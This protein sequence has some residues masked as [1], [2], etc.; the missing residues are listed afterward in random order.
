VAALESDASN[1]VCVLAVEPMYSLPGGHFEFLGDG[2]SQPVIEGAAEEADAEQQRRSVWKDSVPLGDLLLGYANSRGDAAVAAHERASLRDNGTFLVVRKLEQNVALLRAVVAENARLHGVSPEDLYAKLVGRDRAGKAV[3]GGTQGN[4][5]DYANDAGE[6]CPLQ[7]HIRLANPRIERVPRILRRSMSY[8]PPLADGEGRPDLV[9]APRGMFFMAYNASIT[10]Q[11]EVI[12]RWL[13]GANSTGIFSGYGDPLLGVPDREC[14]RIFRFIHDDRAIAC[15]LD[16]LQ[17]H[18]PRPFVQLRWGL[19][20]FMP[21]REGL[22]KILARVSVA[23]ASASI[24]RGQRILEQLEALAISDPDEARDSWRTLLEDPSTHESGARTALWTA[25]R[26]L[27]HGVVKTPYGVVVASA[28]TIETVFRNDSDLYS[29]REYAERMERSAGKIFLGMDRG[30]GYG[31]ESGAALDA[32]QRLDPDRA[33]ANAR[34]H[35]ALA[36]ARLGTLGGAFSVMDVVDYVLAGVSK[37][38]FDLPDGPLEWPGDAAPAASVWV[39]AGPARDPRE[40]YCPASFLMP[41]R[42]MFFPQPTEYVAQAGALSGQLLAGA[43]R[44]F[45]MSGATLQGEISRALQQQIPGDPERLAR[46][47]LGVM[48]GFLPTV[49]GNLLATAHQWITDEELWRLQQDLLLSPESDPLKR[50]QSVLEA[51]LKRAMQKLPT[52]S[53]VHRTAVGVHRLEGIDI[54][55]GDRIVLAIQSA[56]QELYAEGNDDVSLIFGGR[57]GE[58]GPLH[59]CPG[60][61]LAMAVMLGALSALLEAG[62]LRPSGAALSLVLEESPDGGPGDRASAWTSHETHCARARGAELRP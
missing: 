30:A 44:K 36:I 28:K 6:Q 4:D 56:T 38:W 12:Q 34:A 35:A 39:H 51:P 3:C 58:G 41:S 15:D 54:E 57:R 11:F 53:L 42:Y 32:I 18:D 14:R 46:T 61:A 24:E 62:R 1:G 23:A 60:Y 21:S 17:G 19:Y 7:A 40:L 50:A 29:V 27:R 26:T 55:P 48:I 25:I 33:F 31:S 9:D 49:H 43:V 13:S 5:F 47:L 22:R 8:G 59:A 45:I 52:P 16:V 20:L 37:E 10:E 2:L